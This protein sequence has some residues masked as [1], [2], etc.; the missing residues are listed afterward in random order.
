MAVITSRAIG[1]LL[2]KCWHP[3]GE[4]RFHRITADNDRNGFD[5]HGHYTFPLNA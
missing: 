5:Q 2:K 1:N 4:A 3:T